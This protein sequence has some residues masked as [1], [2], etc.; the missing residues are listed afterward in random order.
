[1]RGTRDVRRVSVRKRTQDF[2]TLF[3]PKTGCR[4]LAF[5]RTY[6]VTSYSARGIESELSAAI[7]AAPAP[8][9]LGDA[10]FSDSFESE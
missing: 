6:R 7:A 8:A 9:A 2:A 1:M 5:A 3:K 4:A 10:L